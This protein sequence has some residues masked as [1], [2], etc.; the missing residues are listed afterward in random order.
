[1]SEKP[2]LGSQVVHA[3]LAKPQQG[4]P[5]M[6]G[7]AFASTFHLSG[8]VDPAVHQYARFHN[9]SWDALEAGI[10]ELECGRAIIFPSGMAAAA[11]LMTALVAAGDTILLPSDGYFATRSYADNFLKKF[12]VIVKTAPTVAMLEQDFTGV[13]LV[14]VESPSNPTLDVIDIRALADKVHAANGILAVDNTTL[15]PLGQQP[16]LL[17]ADISMCSDTKA[18]NGHSD[19]LFGHVATQR[20]DLFAAMQLWRKLSG[21]IPGPMETWLVHRGLASLDIRLERMVGNAQVIADYLAQHDKVGLVRYPGLPGDPSHAIA[22]Q[23]CHN[24]GFIISFDL[25]TQ[26]KAQNFLNA[27]QMIFEATS[28]GGLHSIAERRARWG[29]DQVS[30]GLIRLSVGCERVVDLLRDIEQALEQI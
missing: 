3:G 27:S 10:G 5:F 14:F 30:P 4:Q 28:F 1:M 26:A 29:T 8:E 16:L 21:N 7:P 6:S 23:Q 15:T 17:G 20:E 25:G 11:A 24:F 19:V 9:P 22:K 2:S 13:K 12:G 18:L